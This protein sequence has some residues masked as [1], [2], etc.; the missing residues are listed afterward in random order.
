MNFEKL[1]IDIEQTHNILQ[2]NAISFVN[3]NLTVRNWLIG[4]YIIEFE[5]NGNDRAIYGEHL[6]EKLATKLKHIKGLTIS[7]LSRFRIFYQ[8]YPH[9]LGT[10]SQILS[11]NNDL[12]EIKILGTVSQESLQE[13]KFQKNILHEIKPE[14]LLK[15]L[16]YSHFVEIIKIDDPLKRAFYEIECIKANWS[17]R[18]LKR[19]IS[20]LLYERTG[21]S[22][23]KNKAIEKANQNTQI[24]SVSDIIRQPYIFEFLGLKDSD[25]VSETELETAILQHIQNFLIEMGEGFCFEARQKRIPFET[26]YGVIDLVFYHR[27]LKCHILIELKVNEFDYS[28]LTQLNTYVSYY[29][30]NIMQ[31]DDKPTIGILLCTGKDKLMVEYAL[32]GLD[33]KIFVSEYMLYIP[34]KE[35]LEQF[36]KNEIENF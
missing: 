2:K 12:K 36:I 11:Y 21:L 27:I 9:F 29:R 8:Y 10:L 32:A 4:Y 30:K 17:V 14:K 23:N 28:A 19:Q 31:P 35:I 13:T 7:E 18:M 5:Q 6:L 22:K 15:S 33:E 3:I 34:T 1:I 16:S 25:I 24:E 26:T 20:T